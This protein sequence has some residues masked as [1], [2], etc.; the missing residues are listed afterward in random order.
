MPSKKIGLFYGDKPPEA[1]EALSCR[2]VDDSWSCALW[3]GA[4]L[5]VVHN[6]SAGHFCEQIS[7]PEHLKMSLG[8]FPLARLIANPRKNVVVTNQFATRSEGSF[9][10]N[11][12]RGYYDKWKRHRKYSHAFLA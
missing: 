3:N 5:L 8:G 4:G 1:V 7:E 12:A 10:H 2:M 11:F 9:H 6:L